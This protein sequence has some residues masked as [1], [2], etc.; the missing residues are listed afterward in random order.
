MFWAIL[1][2]ASL[3]RPRIIFSFQRSIRVQWLW[4]L[5][6]LIS[7]HCHRHHDGL[8]SFGGILATWLL[9]T[10]ATYIQIID[11]FLLNVSGGKTICC[12]S[13][14]CLASKRKCWLDF[15]HRSRYNVSIY[16]WACQPRR[17]CFSTCAAYQGILHD[18]HP[19]WDFRDASRWNRR[20]PPLR[21]VVVYVGQQLEVL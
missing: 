10:L 19:V 7:Q 14:T 2:R 15:F 17:K 18:S 1:S 3:T 4:R 21:G 20:R 12:L 11:N 5:N 13:G 8:G 9:G 6:A 16:I